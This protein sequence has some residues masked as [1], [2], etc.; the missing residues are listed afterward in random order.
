[1]N[2]RKRL[3]D[4]HLKKIKKANLKENPRK[5]ERYFSKAERD[6]MLTQVM[7][8]DQFVIT[9]WKNGQGSTAQLAINAGGTVDSFDWRISIADVVSDGDYSSFAGYTRYLTMIEGNGTL[10]VHDQEHEDKLVAPFDMAV[11]DGGSS[12]TGTLI[13][14]GI[15]NFNVMVRQGWDSVEVTAYR[16]PAQV[17][18]EPM[19]QYFCY[20]PTR[21]IELIQ[22]S[23]TRVIDSGHLLMHLG[24]Q[25]TVSGEQM[26]VVSF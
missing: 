25:A 23:E 21:T 4:K 11:F 17:V 6:L 3:K 8:P 13:D 16:E 14:G 7:A 26:I 10:L 19:K 9:P 18:L 22:A 24:K 20:S 5:K 15:K 2:R 12:T 1:M